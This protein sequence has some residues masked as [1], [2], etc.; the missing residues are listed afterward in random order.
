MKPQFIPNGIRGVSL[1]K[2]GRE[3]LYIAREPA[4]HKMD[5][6]YWEILKPYGENAT[7]DTEVMYEMFKELC[8]TLKHITEPTR[9]LRVASGGIGMKK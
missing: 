4:D 9:H 1:K 3:F 5:F 6:D 7:M 2:E 8:L